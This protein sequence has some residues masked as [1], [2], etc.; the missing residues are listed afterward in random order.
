MS[1]NCHCPACSPELYPPRPPWWRNPVW[2]KD[3]SFTAAVV[4]LLLGPWLVGVFTIAR[5]LG[6]SR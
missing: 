4:L 5:V 6:G 3:W 2:L 1:G